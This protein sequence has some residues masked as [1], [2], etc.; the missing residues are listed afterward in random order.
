MASVYPAAIYLNKHT[1]SPKKILF[2]SNIGGNVEVFVIN[3]D[4]TVPS[5][6]AIVQDMMELPPGQQMDLVSFFPPIEMPGAEKGIDVYIMNADGTNV[7][8]ITK[9]SKGYSFPVLSPDGR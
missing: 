5:I 7:Q 9:D 4:G 2:E 6:S 1:S 8:R 3:S